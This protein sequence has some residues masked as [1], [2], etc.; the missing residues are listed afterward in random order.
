MK[1]TTLLID[2]DDTILD[3]MTAERT[4]LGESVRALNSEYNDTVFET[5]HLINDLLWKAYER[6]EIEKSEIRKRRFKELYL[7]MGW[8]G[9]PDIMSAL[10]IDNLSHQGQLI[11]GALE[12]LQNMCKK[13]TLYAVTN[14]VDVVQ[15]GRFEVAGI[16]KFFSDVFISEK[17]G[18]GKPDKRYFDFVLEN[19]TERDKTKVAVIGDSPTSDIK[20][21]QNA[22]IDSVW[23]NRNAAMLPNGISPTFT[24]NSFDEIKKILKNA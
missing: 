20:G 6:G 13:Y 9:D 19:I 7:K 12:F 14:G 18:F 4:A 8:G 22:G 15:K 1:Y 21:A 16:N 23:F 10:Y 2:A 5:Y 11:P 24:A 3:F 17:I